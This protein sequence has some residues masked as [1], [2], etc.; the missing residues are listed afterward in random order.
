MHG[1]YCVAHLIKC[2]RISGITNKIKVHV[3]SCVW[4]PTRVG[5]HVIFKQGCGQSSTAG[6]EL[7]KY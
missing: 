7:C 3:S 5:L 1:S 6:M 2:L 4:K